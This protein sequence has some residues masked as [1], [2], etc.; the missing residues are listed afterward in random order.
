MDRCPSRHPALRP[1]R[2]RTAR[3]PPRRSV[4]SRMPVTSA[5]RGF[6][7]SPI[8][9]FDSSSLEIDGGRL[10]IALQDEVVV[11]E[12]LAELRGKA[13]AMKQVGRPA[14]RAAPPCPRTQDRFPRPVVP[15]AFAPCAFSRARSSA[16][17]E[18][19]ISGH[20]GLT[21]RRSNTGTPWS[22]SICASLNSASSDSTTPL[23]IRHC[24][25][26]AGSPRGSATESSS[27]RR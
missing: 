11:V 25:A 6:R 16:T 9:R 8:A 21:R 18:D 7:R 20:A 15:M 27:C 1:A 14:R 24:T 12:N 3:S 10:K 17:C 2:P 5:T 23:P 26:R 4:D 13:L 19:R 22:I